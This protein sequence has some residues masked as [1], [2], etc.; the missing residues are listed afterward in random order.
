MPVIS[1]APERPVRTVSGKRNSA[2]SFAGQLDINEIIT[3]NPIVQEQV[4]NDLVINNIS[5][6][7]TELIIGNKT[8]PAGQAVIF[9]H[10]SG[11]VADSP[12]SV[13]LTILTNSIPSQEISGIVIITVVPD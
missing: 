1:T 2:V 4:T 13:K 7:L 11:V 9:S 12:Y 5:I 3:G 6:S 8:V 10:T